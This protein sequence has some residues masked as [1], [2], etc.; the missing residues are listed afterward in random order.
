[1]TVQ[2]RRCRLLDFGLARAVSA[3][4]AQLTA[5]GAIMGT[6]AYMAPEQARA[7]VVDHRADLWS[8]GVTLYRMTT[9]RLP[10][11]GDGV[12]A[13]LI[14]LATEAPPPVRELN[15]AVPPALAD[16]IG[17]LLSKDPAARPPSADAVAAELARLELQPGSNGEWGPAPAAAR[18]GLPSGLE[19]TALLVPPPPEEAPVG[20]LRAAVAELA[21]GFALVPS[22]ALVC[23][24]PWA[25][26]GSAAR[27]ALPAQAFAL[28]AALAWA[29][30]LI[31]RLPAPGGRAAPGHRALGLLAGLASARW[32]SGA[33]GGRCP[34]PR[35]RPMSWRS[36]ASTCTATRCRRRSATSC[37]SDRPGRCAGG[38]SRPTARGRGGCGS[39]RSRKR[40][41][42][43]SCCWSC[44]RG[45]RPR[46]CW[47][48]RRSPAPRWRCKWS[49]R[50][51]RHTLGAF[52]MRNF[53]RFAL[54]CLALGL[55]APTG[56]RRSAPSE[57]GA[58]GSRA[59]KARKD[60]EDLALG[61]VTAGAAAQVKA[62]AIA[63]VPA[64]PPPRPGP[65]PVIRERVSGPPHPT[66]AEADEAAVAVA[67]E[68]LEHRLAEL[69][70]PVRHAVSPAEVR[71]HYLR[72]E[73]RTTRAGAAGVSVT[74]DVD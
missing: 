45:I 24:A 50:V 72:P 68:V 44:G 62:G 43:A 34:R 13:V 11:G 25:A 8:L 74:Y 2:A 71:A 9:G 52:A 41:R 15:P 32:R 17:R 42:G 39:P 56:C 12:T 35:T 57:G 6:P 36:A 7:G 60:A 33:P 49:A 58:T 40:R 37:T 21:I 16:L 30:L 20:P 4:D 38:G 65:A 61:A 19:A 54:L 31:G 22:A 46:C 5:T 67:A 29:V 63:A 55:A 66:E 47:A 14:A 18:G 64:P 51:T 59:R 3:Q 1:L 28:T 53:W 27:W 26:V 73:T 70:V 48:W 10:F 69:D 23:A